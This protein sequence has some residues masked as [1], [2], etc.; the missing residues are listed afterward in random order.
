[1]SLRSNELADV[2]FNQ[3]MDDGTFKMDE[4]GGDWRRIDEQF[5]D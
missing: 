2:K 5:Q 3:P 1:V 4:I